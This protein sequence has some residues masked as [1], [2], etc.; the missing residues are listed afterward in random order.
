MVK[1]IEYPLSAVE[2][3]INWLYFFHA[4]QLP[5]RYGSLAYVHRCAGCLEQWVEQ[6][7]AM[8]QAK[9]RE[10]VKLFDDAHRLITKFE[11]QYKTYARFGL[12]E[13]NSDGD[14][15]LVY[16]DPEEDQGGS[17]LQNE[18]EE[19]S[20]TFFSDRAPKSEKESPENSKNIGMK[21]KFPR[22]KLKKI[23]TFFEQNQKAPEVPAAEENANCLQ[24]PYSGKENRPF[25]RLPFLRQQHQNKSGKPN[26][27]L[28]DYIRPLAGGIRDRLGVFA[29]TV[30]QAM[31]NAFADD[32]YLHLL[33]QTLA[34][35]LAE[36]TSELLHQQVRT[37]LW[38]Y[39]PEEHLTVAEMFQVK[40]KGIRPAVGY[41]SMPDQSL[42]FL[43]DRLISMHTIGIT[44]TENGAMLPHGSVSGLMFAHPASTY[45]AIGKIG[46][47]QLSDYARR[48][49]LPPDVVRKFLVANL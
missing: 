17:S 24:S 12:F 25:V 18:A 7:P 6:F 41:P 19:A 34:D 30:D 23:P 38:K 42:N 2:P 3:Y 14:D 4:W 45:F 43:I 44:V 27:C 20:G 22:N 48:R 16:P 9:A 13:A 26:L 15:I 31:E 8:E 11:Q 36:A 5:G 39:A 29:T 46:E 40:Y 32:P 33:S 21:F 35:R 10:A 37:D 49:G 28:S 1:T 47:D